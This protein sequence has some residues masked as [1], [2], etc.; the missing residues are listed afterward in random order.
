MKTIELSRG[1]CVLALA[2]AVCASAA[3][4]DRFWPQWRGPRLTGVAP[5][6]NPPVEWSETKNVK[7][8]VEIPGLGSG[9]PVVWEDTLY[10]PTAVPADAATPGGKQRFTLLAFDRKDGKTRWQRVC[11]RSCRTRAPPRRHLRLRL[12]AHRRRAGLRLLRLARP[13]RPRPEG[14]RSWEKDL[15]GMNIKL[16]FGEGA[17][18]ALHGDRLVV[19]WDHEGESFIV[20]LDKK[21]GKELWRAPRDE[22]TSWS[23]PLVVEHGRKRPG[24][25]QRHQ[26]RA[27]LRPGHG[28]AALGGPGMTANAIPTPVPDGD[29][30]Y[31][32]SGFRGNALMAVKLR[33]AK[34]DITGTPAIVWRYDRDTPYVP[35]PLLYGEQLYFLKSNN[36]ILS[37][38][39]P[40]PAPSPTAAASGRARQRLRLAGGR[41]RPRLHRRARGGVAVVEAGPR[42]QAAGPEQAGRRLRRLAG[43]GGR[44]ALPARAQVP[45][46]DLGPLGRRRQLR[47]PPPPAARRAPARPARTS[48]AAPRDR[49]SATSTISSSAPVR[50][51]N[52]ASP[53]R[54]VSGVPDERARQRLVQHAPAPA[55]RAVHDSSTGGGSGPGSPAAQVARRPAAAR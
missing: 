44:R 34:G 20:A 35:S 46:P 15:G 7:W 52:A 11:A 29:V 1:A 6:G 16:G 27:Q 14:Q 53:S 10:V 21:T 39:T 37:A 12:R 26:P 24:R 54:T 5:Q 30:V 32:T 40:R 18:P 42:V 43:A 48:A 13:L 19:N 4:D 2:A 23:T 22:K 3:A 41:R 8:K 9:T 36:G 33:A 17:S 47:R 28:Q 55:G 49:R 45:V 51:T 31:L 50:A 25:H 38:S